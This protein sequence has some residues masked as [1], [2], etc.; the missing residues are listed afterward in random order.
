MGDDSAT[1]LAATITWILKGLY[2]FRPTL[3]HAVS[4]FL[5][6]SLLFFDTSLM[7]DSSQSEMSVQKGKDQASLKFKVI[8]CG[9]AQFF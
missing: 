6:S 4:F 7:F 8:W 1:A 5:S 2:M 3:R 9:V